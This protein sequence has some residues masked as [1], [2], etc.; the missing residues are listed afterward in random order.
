MSSWQLTTPDGPLRWGE[1]TV[2]A[3][4]D[5]SPTG[6]RLD[7]QLPAAAARALGEDDVVRSVRLA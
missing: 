3:S 4:L 5:G 7:L 6:P 2:I 1:W